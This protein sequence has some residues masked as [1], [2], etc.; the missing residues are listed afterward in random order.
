MVE[1]PRE[2]FREVLIR[3][4]ETLLLPEVGELYT[5][6]VARCLTGDVACPGIPTESVVVMPG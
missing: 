6:V 5:R 3:N 4:I 1:K 2:A